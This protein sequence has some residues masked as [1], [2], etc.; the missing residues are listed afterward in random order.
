MAAT[1]APQAGQWRGSSVG[2]GTLGSSA[3]II[4][5]TTARMI[6]Q[7]WDLTNNHA[8]LVT[9]HALELTCAQSW[10]ILPLPDIL[11]TRIHANKEESQC[12]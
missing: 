10:D 5:Q 1:R 6:A 4:H 7:K 9:A 8:G 2:R 11:A 3:I 12:P